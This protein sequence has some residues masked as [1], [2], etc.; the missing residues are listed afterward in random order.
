MTGRLYTLE[1]RDKTGVFLGMSVPELGLIGGGLM[2]AVLSRLAGAPTLVSAAPLLIGFGLAKLRVRGRRLREWATLLVSWTGTRLSGRRS[3]QARLPLFPVTDSTTAALPPMLRDIDVVEIPWGG[4]QLAA[5]R[6]LRT[7]RLTAVCVVAGPQFV[8]Q[9]SSS[10][11][12][13]LAS[14]GDVLAAPAVPGSPVV[15]VG[16]S[17]TAVPADL[18]EH[19]SWAEARFAGADD[20]AGGIAS[21]RELLD[22]VTGAASLHETLVWI[23]VAGSRVRDTHRDPLERAAAHLPAAVENLM[24]AL[25]AAALHTD[26]PLPA[27]GLWQLLRARI[28]P[29]DH[30]LRPDSASGSLAQRLGLV[31]RHNAGPLAVSTAWGQLRMDGSFHRAYWIEAW[32][33]RPV[34]ADWLH[35]FLTTAECRTMTVV[36][37]PIAPE[38]SLRRIESQLVKLSAH[39]MR[40]EEKD[41]R[42]TEAD[43]RTEQAAYDLEAEL[44]SG[45]A[46]TLYLGL[47]TVSAPSAAELDASARRIEQAARARGLALRLLHG[48]QDVAW[49]ASLPFGLVDPGLLD[50]V[51]V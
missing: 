33:R 14:W 36:H 6:D 46:E 50:L 51:G 22:E 21:Y 44:A 12:A 15:Q 34:P 49:A 4:R 28:D 3:W 39:R 42:V 37:W 30:A 40:K 2:L 19:R 26:G 29:A 48:S 25:E 43:R 7:E 47:V 45:H 17:D 24:A 38:R 16:W 11:D 20:L 41:R 18:A 27:A 23:T 10:Q 9:D 32:P 5:V 31:G 35:G 8:C 1:P 13:L